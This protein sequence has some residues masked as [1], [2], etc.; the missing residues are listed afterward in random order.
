VARVPGAAFSGTE[1]LSPEPA[2]LVHRKAQSQGSPVPEW[3]CPRGGVLR[4]GGAMTRPCR[5]KMATR[6]W[7]ERF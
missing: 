1:A 5:L 2:A 3:P 7:L 6:D 4:N